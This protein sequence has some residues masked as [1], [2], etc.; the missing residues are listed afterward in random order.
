MRYLTILAALA[1]TSALGCSPNQPSPTPDQIRENTAAATAKAASDIKAA[2]EGV[3][4]GLHQTSNPHQDTVN[5]NT[6]SRPTLET[7]QGVDPVV[8]NLIV[9]HRPYSDPSDLVKKHVLTQAQYDPI[10]GRL[11]TN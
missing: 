11:T 6:A 8:A 7:L 10:A 3:R 1:V 9:R 5:I 4:D 2:A